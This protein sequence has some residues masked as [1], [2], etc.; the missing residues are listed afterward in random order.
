[1]IKL[2]PHSGGVCGHVAITNNTI[3]QLGTGWGIYGESLSH[4]VIS[5]NQLT[6]ASAPAY[7]GIYVRSV[8]A[9]APVVGLVIQ[10]NEIA[11]PLTYG[12]QLHASPGTF[13]AGINVSGNVA[14]DVVFPLYLNNPGGFAAPVVGSPGG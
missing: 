12:V 6:F 7:S 1:V 3:N 4:A 2:V 10:G 13:G 11:G 14:P 5:G 9:A 8:M